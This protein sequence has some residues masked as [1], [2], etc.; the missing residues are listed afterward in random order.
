MV[1][2]VWVRGTMAS[3]VSFCSGLWKG[4]SID[5]VEEEGKFVQHTL[6]SEIR[7][8]V[9]TCTTRWMNLTQQ[10]FTGQGNESIRRRM[11]CLIAFIVSQDLLSSA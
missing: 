1:R 10:I 3:E 11:S 2:S 8:G 7:P 6:G 5:Q 9:W 4:L